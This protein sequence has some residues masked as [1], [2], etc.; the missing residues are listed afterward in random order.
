MGRGGGGRAVAEHLLLP[1]SHPSPATPLAHLAAA[2]P[3]HLTLPP[4]AC[5]AGS[6]TL[7]MLRAL[8]LLACTAKVAAFAQTPAGEAGCV[9][10]QS[11]ASTEVFQELPVKVRHSH[12]SSALLLCSCLLLGA[13]RLARA[14]TALRLA[15]KQAGHLHAS[16]NK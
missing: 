9:D 15:E 10:M 7:L 3:L 8:L 5:G 2:A 11:L 4:S 1:R 16:L 14:W 6:A 12:L 13:R